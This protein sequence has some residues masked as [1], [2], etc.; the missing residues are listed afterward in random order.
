[1]LTFKL[2]LGLASRVGVSHFPLLSRLNLTSPL[3][4]RPLCITRPN[5]AFYHMR[6][7]SA[8]GPATGAPRISLDPLSLLWGSQGWG[9]PGCKRQ[10]VTQRREG[11]LLKRLS[12]LL[13]TQELQ[14][15]G[16]GCPKAYSSAFS[17]LLRTCSWLISGTTTMF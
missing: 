3:L 12:E 14:Q 15:H 11:L 5:S 10:P 4:G 8:P 6:S 2:C 13:E 17:F 16:V 1:M 7:H 9:T